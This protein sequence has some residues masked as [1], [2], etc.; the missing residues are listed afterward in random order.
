MLENGR[1][2]AR[3]FVGLLENCPHRHD[4]LV[5]NVDGQRFIRTALGAF[6]H[7]LFNKFDRAVSRLPLKRVEA[8]RLAALEL[9]VS[10]PQAADQQFSATVFVKEQNAQTIHLGQHADDKS[11]QHG[12]TRAGHAANERVA[13]VFF[14]DAVSADDGLV[15]VEVVRLLGRCFEQRHGLTPGV[16]VAL[17]QITVV[18]GREAGEIAGCQCGNPG[19]PLPITG[20]LCEVCALGNHID[21]GDFVAH[22]FLQRCAR[23]GH[24]FAHGIDILSEDGQAV[25]VLAHQNAAVAH[26]FKRVFHIRNLRGGALATADE[27]AALQLDRLQAIA[28]SKVAE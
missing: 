19:P 27:A 12:F 15:Q 4:D 10:A 14:T 5:L 1:D 22:V 25:V 26:V 28:F 16:V 11:E 18:H 23:A 9:A 20:Q 8:C 7:E 21:R 17:A 6:H 13:R 24:A 3:T 2:T